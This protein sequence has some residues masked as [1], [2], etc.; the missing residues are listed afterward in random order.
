MFE[1]NATNNKK[2]VINNLLM[3][4]LLRVKISSIRVPLFYIS[5]KIRDLCTLDINRGARI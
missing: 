1:N 3:I 4:I 5:Y 2:Y